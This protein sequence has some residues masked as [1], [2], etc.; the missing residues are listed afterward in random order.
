M[1]WSDPAICGCSTRATRARVDRDCGQRHDPVR[2]GTRR[3]QPYPRTHPIRA[4][5]RHA[6]L[7][8]YADPYGGYAPGPR[9]PE[10]VLDT[11][12]RGPKA[13][14]QDQQP[15]ERTTMTCG[16][17]AQRRPGDAA[18]RHRPPLSR[19]WRLSAAQPTA[20]APL[21]G[22]RPD[23]SEGHAAASTYKINRPRGA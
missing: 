3:F 10:G 15:L 19:P 13:P 4:V 7:T 21:P 6:Q 5:R 12:R 22:A 14:E 17:K 11:P 8:P 16:G 9:T 20:H 1:P 23:P 18:F 2:G